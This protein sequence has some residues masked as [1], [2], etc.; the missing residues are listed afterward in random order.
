LEF[1]H[2]C[3]C[4]LFLPGGR[5]DEFNVSQDIVGRLRVEGDDGHPE[6]FQAVDHI[7]GVAERG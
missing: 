1:P 3:R 6:R 4:L 7:F 2:A 5:S